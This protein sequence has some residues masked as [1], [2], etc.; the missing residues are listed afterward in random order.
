[1]IE[2]R[3]VG[4]EVV[5]VEHQKDVFPD[6][7][8]VAK[9]AV[10]ALV[11]MGIE[12]GKTSRGESTRSSMHLSDIDPSSSFFKENVPLARPNCVAFIRMFTRGQVERYRP[13]KLT[14]QLGHW[15]VSA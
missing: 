12:G 9:V 7:K 5:R 6:K 1:V 2:Q 11:S 10:V 13:T 15:T 8:G 14:L 4:K 3:V